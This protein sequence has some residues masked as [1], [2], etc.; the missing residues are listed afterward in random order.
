MLIV[1]PYVV[2]NVI[3]FETITITKSFGYN[4][5]KGNNS[6][7]LVEGNVIIDVANPRNLTDHRLPKPI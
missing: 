4:L 3:L 2:R 1:S 7:S 6:N 5:W